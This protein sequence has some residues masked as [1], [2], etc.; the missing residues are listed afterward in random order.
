MSQPTRR[1]LLRALA[2]GTAAAFLSPLSA[3]AQ[4]LAPLTRSIPSSGEALPVVGLG[5]WITFNVGDDPELRD[6]CTAVMQAFFREGG[7]LIDSSPMYGSSQQVVGYG[8]AKLERP[9]TLFCADKVWIGSG[10][11]G[12]AQIEESR[13]RWGIRRFDLLQVHNLLAWEDA[14]PD[15][16]RDEARRPAPLR[17]HH[18]LRGPAARRDRADHA[19]RSR[20][21]SSRSATTPSIA[22]SRA[23][24]SRWRRIAASR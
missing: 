1:D 12:P 11:R 13:A 5:S 18:H 17:R 7:R 6:E 14:S 16:A 21:I 9:S 22:R 8:L 2:A 15:A 4:P 24:S 3:F 20:S 19:S 10:E 23:A